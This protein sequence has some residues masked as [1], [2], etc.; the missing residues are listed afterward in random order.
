MEEKEK[1]QLRE[2]LV[3]AKID[4]LLLDRFVADLAAACGESCYSGCSK[5]CSSGTANRAFAELR[6]DIGPVVR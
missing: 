5:C 2:A 3:K 4:Q 6:P 1:I